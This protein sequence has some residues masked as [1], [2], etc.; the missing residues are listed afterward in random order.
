MLRSRFLLPWF[1]GVR[2]CPCHDQVLTYRIT[3]GDNDRRFSINPST[4]VITVAKATLDFEAASLYDL[5]VEVRFFAAHH[6]L[7]LSST[8]HRWLC[9]RRTLHV[10]VWDKFAATACPVRVV[11]A[12]FMCVCR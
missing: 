9:C 10:P 6:L 4:G 3:N 12:S 7:L 1:R 11:V 2:A 5:T 8:M